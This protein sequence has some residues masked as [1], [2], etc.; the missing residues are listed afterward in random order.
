MLDLEQAGLQTVLQTKANPSK[1][2]DAKLPVYG[3]LPRT[4][5]LPAIPHGLCTERLIQ[6][7]RT[8]PPCS[9]VIFGAPLSGC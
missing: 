3:F 5:G 4:A 9:F 8:A 6:D 2:G 7:L 1:G